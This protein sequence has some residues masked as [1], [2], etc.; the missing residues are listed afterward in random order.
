MVPSRAA[1]PPSRP[2]ASTRAAQAISSSVG[3][4]PAPAGATW[5]GWMSNLP[6]NPSEAA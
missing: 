4:K 2:A 1:A 3:R 6:P 5:A